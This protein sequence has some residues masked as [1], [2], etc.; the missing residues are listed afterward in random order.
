MHNIKANLRLVTVYAIEIFRLEDIL[1]T[2]VGHTA[3]LTGG[4]DF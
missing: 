1:A 2:S 4:F 3:T